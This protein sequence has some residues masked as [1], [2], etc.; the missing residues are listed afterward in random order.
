MQTVSF[1]DYLHDVSDSNLYPFEN[2]VTFL[3]SANG[4]LIKEMAKTSRKIRFD[5]LR[6]I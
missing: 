6:Q 5:K 3:L 2:F 4:N 1:G